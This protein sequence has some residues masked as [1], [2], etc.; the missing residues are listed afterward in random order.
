MDEGIHIDACAVHTGGRCN[1]G[2]SLAALVDFPAPP[3]SSTRPSRSMC[4]ALLLGAAV[5]VIAAV[6][7]FA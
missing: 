5:L 4:V 1:C 2:E 3:A 6:W 7:A